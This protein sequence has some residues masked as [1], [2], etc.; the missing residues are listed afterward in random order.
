MNVVVRMPSTT[1]YILIGATVA[2]V[3]HPFFHAWLV[4]RATTSLYLVAQCIVIV[5]GQIYFAK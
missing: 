2:A 1:K 5:P 4:E 3:F